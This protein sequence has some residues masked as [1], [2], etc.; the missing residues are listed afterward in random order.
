MMCAQAH[1]AGVRCDDSL[2]LARLSARLCDAALVH[3]LHGSSCIGSR[4]RQRSLEG[5]RSRS[6]PVQLLSRTAAGP[7]L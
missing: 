6:P 1:T 4:S 7:W 2:R 5:C 3:T